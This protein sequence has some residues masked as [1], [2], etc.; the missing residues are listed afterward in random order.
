M[1]QNREYTTTY[2]K[3][4][5]RTTSFPKSHRAHVDIVY[6]DEL[7]EN[8]KLL[9]EVIDNLKKD[10]IKWVVLKLSLNFIVPKNAVWYQNKKTSDIN[11]H[12]EDFEKIYLSNLNSLVSQDMIYVNYNKID[13]DGWNH[14]VDKKKIK[15]DKVSRVRSEI[16]AI[17]TDWTELA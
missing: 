17:G 9:E 1:L 6:F 8:I 10:D 3:D 2:S 4:M 14:H 12:I 15:A 13:D 7:S 11:C 16:S 5:L